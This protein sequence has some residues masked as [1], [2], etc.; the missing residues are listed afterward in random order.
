MFIRIPDET[1]EHAMRR[2]P[3][4]IISARDLI[5][6]DSD[7]IRAQALRAWQ[8]A[9]AELADL[10]NRWK[11]FQ[12]HD[13][14]AFTNWYQ[15]TFATLIQD[16]QNCRTEIYKKQALIQQVMAEAQAR[17]IPFAEAYENVKSGNTWAAEK[18]ALENE[19]DDAGDEA[20]KEAATRELF[21]RHLTNMG[22]DPDA[23]DPEDYRQLFEEFRVH[24]RGER[25]SEEHSTDE[26]KTGFEWNPPG[27]AQE[28]TEAPSERSPR[29]QRLKSIYRK[30]ALKLH[31][32]ASGSVDPALSALWLQVQ[33]ANETS[34][35]E[36]LERIWNELG[37]PGA[38]DTSEETVFNLRRRV[39]EMFHT[40]R[41]MQKRL[42]KAQRD[43]AWGFS[44]AGRKKRSKKLSKKIQS[45][46]SE[47]LAEHQEAL[48]ALEK[49]VEAWATEDE[50]ATG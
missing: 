7:S 45:D 36:A 49:F 6:I 47:E 13:Q 15:A 21:E 24:L 39:A 28:K 14:S 17:R 30:L 19:E 38:V 41:T 48:E 8:E 12:A 46:L 37:A 16:I 33:R 25:V 11:N 5:L 42:L 3:P 2:I 9:S 23:M 22:V 35:L 50:R 18:E 31:P 26:E 44:G 29:E 4:P 20:L 27:S 10:Q 1:G 40:I 34:D 32:D 43:P